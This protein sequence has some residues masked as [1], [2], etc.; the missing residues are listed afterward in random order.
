MWK[1]INNVIFVLFFTAFIV[2]QTVYF[3]VSV[4]ECVCPAMVSNVWVREELV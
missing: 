2:Y 4:C 3:T 1:G